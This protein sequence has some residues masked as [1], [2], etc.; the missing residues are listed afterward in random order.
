MHML[1]T[2]F[3][4]QCA[5][6]YCQV[7]WLARSQENN[8]TITPSLGY[9]CRRSC[10]SDVAI[11]FRPSYNMCSGLLPVWLYFATLSSAF[12]SDCSILPLFWEWYGMGTVPF[13]AYPRCGFWMVG[14]LTDKLDCYPFVSLAWKAICWPKLQMCS[15]TSARRCII[16]TCEH[17]ETT[18]F[19]WWLPRLPA[20]SN[21][22][23]VA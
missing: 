21:A 1:P 18:G 9:A 10:C 2:L 13:E 23:M 14:L 12:T 22:L 3:N 8:P 16:W 5:Y 19:I 17:A 4:F 7:Q 20:C 15:K 6:K 11:Q